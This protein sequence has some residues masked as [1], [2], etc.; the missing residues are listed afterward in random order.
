M[1]A[2]LVYLG[3]AIGI[4]FDENDYMMEE[5]SDVTE[6][7]KAR[8]RLEK[9]NLLLIVT[10]NKDDFKFF[11]CNVSPGENEENLKNIVEVQL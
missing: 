5:D 11:V 3:Y 1:L 8:S 10:F 7:T 2:N 6:W 9:F 4:I